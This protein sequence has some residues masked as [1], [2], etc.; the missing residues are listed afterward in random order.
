MREVTDGLGRRVQVTDI[1]RAVSLAPNITESVFAIGAGDRLVG[2]TTFCDHPAEARSIARVGDTM[3]PNLETI[4]ALAPDV[5]LVSTASQV[6]A[7]TGT[8]E[9]NGIAVYVTDPDSVEAVVETL[10]RLGELFGTA[11]TA[12]KAAAEL[13]RRLDVAAER[14]AGREPVRVF[15][16]ISREPLFT[17]GRTSFVTGLLHR[18]GAV[19]VTEDI[20]TA[21][22]RLSKETAASLDPDVIILSASEDNR[23]PNDVFRSSRAVKNGRVISVDPNLLS[24]PGP[25]IADAVEII[26]RSLDEMV[27]R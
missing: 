19:S 4:V 18:A 5:V 22:P 20:E 12:S 8:L 15:V 23:E 25:R 3:N 26:A 13:Q 24:R 7:F 9:R 1:K 6:E 2:V 14:S 17:A 16:Q 10:V 21:Y 11:E 27:T